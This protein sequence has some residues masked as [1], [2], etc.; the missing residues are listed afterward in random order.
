MSMWNIYRSCVDACESITFHMFIWI[1][2]PHCI[3]NI[4]NSAWERQSCSLK[5]HVMTMF[6][7]GL[8]TVIQTLLIVNICPHSLIAHSIS[9]TFNEILLTLTLL[10]PLTFSLSHSLQAPP[11]HTHTCTKRERLHNHQPY[12]SCKFRFN[13]EC[14]VLCSSCF[15][16]ILMLRLC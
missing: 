16:Q 8:K 11:P 6:D 4:H 1:E 15:H 9:L 10:F 5:L 3:H 14:Q 13:F 7:M 2:K 12:D